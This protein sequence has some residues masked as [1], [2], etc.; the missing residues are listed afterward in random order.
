[1][2]ESERL[3]AK[4]GF[5]DALTA[6]FFSPRARADAAPF[7]EN[8][9]AFSVDSAVHPSDAVEGSRLESL[10]EAV[11]KNYLPFAIVSGAIALWSLLLLLGTLRPSRL[12][13]I[14]GRPWLEVGHRRFMLSA[15]VGSVMGADRQE[16]VHHVSGS[17]SRDA[18]GR[19]V[20]SS[21]GRSYQVVKD[22][23]IVN[24]EDGKEHVVRLNNWDVVARP[25]HRIAVIALIERSRN[26]GHYVLYHN[27]NLRETLTD[28]AQLHP[29]LRVSR[30]L[31]FVFLLSVMATVG[32]LLL[33]KRPDPGVDELQDGLGILGLIALLGWIVMWVYSVIRTNFAV[34]TFDR[35]IAPAA[36][37]AVMN[38]APAR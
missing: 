17:E 4:P 7:V 12:V 20:S 32:V 35:H 14:D 31:R 36:I 1:V 24:G 29:S 19:L 30:R 5:L 6:Q 23:L 15:V 33:H 8:L 11:G 21:P 10:L 16:E 9:R 25:G 26:P 34:R 27:A 22:R 38:Q 37:A 13:T 18:D 3:R 28:H 2:S